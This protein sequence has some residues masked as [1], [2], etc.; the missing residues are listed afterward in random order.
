M[1]SHSDQSIDIRYRFTRSAVTALSLV[2][3]MIYL[4]GCNP[5][6]LQSD[7]KPEGK[8]ISLPEETIEAETVT[9]TASRNAASRPSSDSE[10]ESVKKSQFPL[11]RVITNSTGRSISGAI[12][13][14]EGELIAFKRDTDG[15]AFLI[16]ISQLSAKD[17]LDL[18]ELSDE[19]VETVVALQSQQNAAGTKEPESVPQ[20]QKIRRA[21]W[22]EDPDAAFAESK[23]LGLPVYVLFTG[24][25]WCPPCKMLEKTVHKNSEFSDF[26]DKNLVLLMVDFPKRKSQNVKVKERNQ[27][28]ATEF[29]ISVYPTIIL[30]NGAKGTRETIQRTE[31]IESFL[32]GIEEAISKLPKSV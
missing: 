19:S 31:S 17:Q 3:G 32:S 23:A 8:E 7:L 11:S 4:S 20:K 28:L 18:I 29:G 1:K 24:S 21:E 27:E 6:A 9:D 26:A 10:I 25:D 30:T 13:G 16:S 14:K 12:I 2:V 5:P 22:H 15:K